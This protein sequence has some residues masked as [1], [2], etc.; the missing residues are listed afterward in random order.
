MHKSLALYVM[1]LLPFIY[2]LTFQYI[3]MLGN[4]IAFQDYKIMKGFFGSPW[5]G[6]KYFEQFLE[7]PY[8]WQV[9]R[10]T[11]LINL[12]SLI[13]FFPSSII[14]AL[15]LNELMSSLFK[16]FVQTITYIP[17]FLSTVVIAGMLVNFL[18]NKGLINQLIVSLGGESKTFLALPEWF[19]TIYISSDIW[20]GLGWN[21]I[22]YLAALTS[23][24]PQQY[25]AATID[26]ANRWRRL[27]HITLPGISTV[28]TIML[29]LQIGHMLSVGFEKIILLYSGPTYETADVIQ[30]Y[31][32]RR[33]LIDADFSFAAAVG[34]FQSVIGFILVI[35][36]NRIARKV[37]GT[38]LF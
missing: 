26:G 33:G 32:Y 7:D 24:D 17:H 10:N 12:Y 16:R 19:R 1:F 34:I 14:F 23:I 6:T 30:T 37:N 15:L 28:V 18:S 5:V 3:P 29:L 13:F 11:L 38:R 4:L 21:S 35:G 2:F 36:A 25:E 20:Q 31:V 9:L 22:I 27:I 8:F